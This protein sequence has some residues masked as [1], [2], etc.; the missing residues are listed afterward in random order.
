MLIQNIKEHH[1][2]YDLRIHRISMHDEWNISLLTKLSKS[3]KRL[4][5]KQ[6]EWWITNYVAVPHSVDFRKHKRSSSIWNQSGT[7]DEYIY[8]LVHQPMDIWTLLEFDVFV[9]S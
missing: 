4:N 9:V 6:F 5:K 2:E 8:T 3:E 1:F 7:A